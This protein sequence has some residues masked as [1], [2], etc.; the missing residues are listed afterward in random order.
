V[1]EVIRALPVISK[2][3]V[4]RRSEAK[5]KKKKFSLQEMTA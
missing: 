1:P 2:F 5:S 4:N 3:F